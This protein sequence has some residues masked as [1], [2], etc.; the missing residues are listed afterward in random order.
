MADQRRGEQVEPEGDVA[1]AGFAGAV[2][3]VPAHG[4]GEYGKTGDKGHRQQQIAAFQLDARLQGGGD[5]CDGSCDHRTSS[6]GDGDRHHEAAPV[7]PG[8]EGCQQAD[9]CGPDRAGLRGHVALGAGEDF[10]WRCG[11][12]ARKGHQQDDRGQGHAALA[13]EVFRH[14]PRGCGN[15]NAACS[16]EQRLS[17]SR[18]RDHQQDSCDGHE[19][20]VE[21]CNQAEVF[22]IDRRRGAQAM[23]MAAQGLGLLVSQGTGGYRGVQVTFR[24]HR[25]SPLWMW[26]NALSVL[27][28]QYSNADCWPGG[29]S[30]SP[31][32]AG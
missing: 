15:Q 24:I 7:E 11:D 32:A 29:I 30:P 18:H 4:E 19:D 16:R 13:G 3:H 10:D 27:L 26:E 23:D 9:G 31:F 17:D 20:I 8:G 25:H 22:F 1:A 5:Q 2:G 12:A 14:A 21:A 6:G 28:R